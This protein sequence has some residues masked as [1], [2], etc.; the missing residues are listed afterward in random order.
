[1]GEVTLVKYDAIDGIPTL[2]DSQITLLYRKSKAEGTLGWAFS[3]IDCD[4]YLTE[5][6]FLAFYKFGAV[7]MWVV[8]YDGRIAGWIWLDDIRDR[9]CRLHYN[10]FKWAI[11]K[12]LTQEIGIECL[13]YFFKLE[14]QNNHTIFDVIRGETPS[15]NKLAVGYLKKLGMKVVGSIDKMAWNSKRYKAY[16]MVISYI[17]RELLE[18]HKQWVA[19]HKPL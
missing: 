1:M 11:R 10:F 9:N 18:E 7:K 2:K 14:N 6:R 5:E 12:G 19:K 3:S 17:T 15:F 16:P 4:T 8:L 13:D